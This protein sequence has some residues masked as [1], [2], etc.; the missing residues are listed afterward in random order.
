MIDSTLPLL[1]LFFS[2]FTS[3]TLLPGSSEA[4]FLFMLSQQS[5]NTGV[6][7]LV[8]GV[9]NSLGGMTNWVLG[10]LI[11]KGLIRKGLGK[12]KLSDSENKYRY[13]AERWLHQ[14]G[15]PVLFFSFLPIIGDPLCLVA[16]LVKIHWLKALLYI[17]AGKFFRY[18][19]LS[20]LLNI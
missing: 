8:V 11:R 5:W 15:S 18:F 13:Q 6:L 12:E 2:G 7:I 20:Y 1:T 3:A 16:G 17:S 4:L 14:Y 10:T 9:G 19:I